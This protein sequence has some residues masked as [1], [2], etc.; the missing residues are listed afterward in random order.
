MPTSVKPRRP[1]GIS[2]L[3]VLELL[4]DAP[5]GKGVREIAA[6][7]D[8]DVG[9][10]HR[11]LQFLAEDDWVVQ[12]A[13][14]GPYFL[15]GRVLA[16]AGKLLNRID[17]RD[18]ARPTLQDLHLSTGETVGL[19]ELRG[20]TLICIDRFRSD[21]HISVGAQIG[22][23]IPFD[24]TAV[25]TTVRASWRRQAGVG[26]A[27]ATWTSDAEVDAAIAQ[28]YALSDRTYRPEVRAV[29]AT[30]LDLEDRPVGAIFVVAPAARVSLADMEPLGK[31][32][33]EAAARVS[34]ALGHRSGDA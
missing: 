15:T 24:G 2:G 19:A 27:A 5:G 18:I 3:R 1:T 8:L 14:R 32:T 10:T 23:V 26:R 4:A 12:H 6:D 9:Q 33:A 21:H 31:Q 20:D 11:L 13:E 29:A 30:V 16:L 17:L 22:D 28:G 34:A 25:G 7:V